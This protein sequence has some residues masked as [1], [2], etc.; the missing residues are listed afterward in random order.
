MPR[1]GHPRD[2]ASA[3]LLPGEV[4]EHPRH[5]VG[6]SGI[7]LEL[8]EAESEEQRVGRRRDGHD[9][10]EAVGDLEVARVVG[11]ALRRAQDRPGAEA[12]PRSRR[13]R[14]A[15]PATTSLVSSTMRPAPRRSPG[16]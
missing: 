6:T 14:W 10:A 4:G 1:R 5:H 15:T 3:Q 12:R 13:P 2:A 8:L 9:V 7:R 11:A 16:R